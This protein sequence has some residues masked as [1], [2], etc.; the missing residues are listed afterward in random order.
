MEL[1][2][3]TQAY[4]QWLHE[5]GIDSSKVDMSNP[6]VVGQMAAEAITREMRG[7]RDEVTRLKSTPPP[8]P[9]APPAAPLEPGKGPT[10]VTGAGS[11]V[12][13]STKVTFEDLREIVTKQL[14]RRASD[15]DV[16]EAHRRKQIDLNQIVV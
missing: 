8:Q 12:A 4:L 2:R 11:G 1:Q 9:P 15:F 14:G 7:L 16:F 3:Q 10:V 5:L 13:P 6:A